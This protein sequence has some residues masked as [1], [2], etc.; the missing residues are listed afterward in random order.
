MNLPSFLS[1]SYRVEIIRSG[2]QSSGLVPY[3]RIH[4]LSYWP[5]WQKINEN[6][7][8]LL[9]QKVE[10]LTALGRIQGSFSDTDIS[11]RINDIIPCVYSDEE[12]RRHPNLHKLFINRWRSTWINHAGTIALRKARRD[13]LQQ[14][15]LL[16]EQK[17]KEKKAKKEKADIIKKR[18]ETTTATDKIVSKKKKTLKVLPLSGVVVTTNSS[19]LHTNSTTVL[20]TSPLFI[21]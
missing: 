11:D 4:I 10:E 20:V 14:Q 13:E 3:N 17:D 21:R 12:I 6:Q 7:C 16:Q 9:L 1:T 15:K 2:W 19:I 18:K 8:I 5:G